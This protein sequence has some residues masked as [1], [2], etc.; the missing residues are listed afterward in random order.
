MEFVFRPSS[1]VV[2]C[3]PRASA[4]WSTRRYLLWPAWEYHVLA[5]K[6]RTRTLN[7]IEKAVLGL[8]RA[9]VPIITQI[10]EALRIGA[11]L[12]ARVF[13][14]LKSGGLI[15]S[16]GILSERG[17]EVL[18]L[19]L[20][21][22]PGELASGYVYQ[23]PWNGELWP[24]FMP[25]R[26][27][28]DTKALDRGFQ[29]LV[30]GTRGSPRME[31][32]FTVLP[33][34]EETFVVTPEVGQVLAASWL[35]SRRLTRHL[36]SDF[37]DES[38]D[39]VPPPRPSQLGRVA[40]IESEPT[41]VLL[42]TFIY[43][44]ED[45]A[46]DGGWL[47]C[48]PFGTGTSYLFRRA[49]MR[50][51]ETNVGLSKVVAEMLGQVVRNSSDP[52]RLL[53]KQREQ[54]ATQDVFNRLGSVNDAR[55]SRRLIEMAMNWIE[56]NQY[57]LTCPPDRLEDAMVKAGK[58]ME[59]GLRMLVRSHPPDDGWRKFTHDRVFNEVLLNKIAHKIGFDTPVP[60]AVAGI[61]RGKL[62]SVIR[63]GKGT[64]NVLLVSALLTANG[65]PGHPIW[66]I[67]RRMPQ[68]L[69]WLSEL[70]GDRDA[71]AHDNDGQVAKQ[72][73]DKHISRTYEMVELLRFA[74]EH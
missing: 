74:F 35:F 59:R 49:I 37:E 27:F 52:A 55:L 68:F 18:E 67:A 16:A 41:P 4:R 54:Q 3:G 53:Q 60:R 73:V 2:D 14:D 47:A 23:D 29:S 10:A 57:G 21:E 38:E 69:S 39:L 22:D 50:R 70:A 24:A 65:S 48:D 25:K 40:F 72:K 44:P 56:V 26:E 28:A 64:L 5:P 20:V 19:E 66:K 71:V 17:V 58:V 7:I 32:P 31:K 9:N 8:C 30:L 6:Q 1:V 42:V 43:T 46:G 51:I 33:E 34:A 15:D 12:A 61:K 36:M 13:D 45:P 63:S 11:D 62:E